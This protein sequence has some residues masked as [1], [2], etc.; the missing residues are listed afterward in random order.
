MRVV[1]AGLGRTGTMSLKAALEKL[2]G[3]DCYHMT[4]VFADPQHVKLWN[5]AVRAGGEPSG[6][7]EQ[8]FG[9]YV[10]TVDWPS[11]SF[12]EQLAAV[13]PDAVILASHRP[14]EAWWKS[15]DATIWEVMRRGSQEGNE[16]WYS[17]VDALFRHLFTPEYLTKEGSIAAYEAHYENV[18]AKADPDRL[19]WWSPG[20]GW[21][22]ICEALQIPVPDEGFPHAN[23]TD[24]FRAMAGFDASG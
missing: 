23:T 19:V 1:G 16:S 8:I 20:D 6:G 10:A 4:E 7:W 18:R 12:W 17:M 11:C 24:D 15:A 9:S 5:E 3:G 22:P 14:A 21:G 13:Y 2:L